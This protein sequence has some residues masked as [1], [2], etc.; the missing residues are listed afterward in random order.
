MQ[1]PQ[2]LQARLNE[3]LGAPGPDADPLELGLRSV[4]HMTAPTIDAVLAQYDDHGL[5]QALEHVAL[6]F[7]R[8]R[9]DG[10]AFSPEFL[11]ELG[12]IQAEAVT[13]PE[14]IDADSI[15]EPAAI[16]SPGL[17]AG[18][19]GPVVPPAPAPAS[20][21]TPASTPATSPSSAPAGSDSSSSSPSPAGSDAPGSGSSSGEEHPP[22]PPWG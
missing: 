1:S 11:D 4:V 8:M 15:E 17:P 18:A 3:L 21:P 16:A 7:V 12:K 9:S 2:K 19:P 20:D 5:D 13:H 10:S 14:A 22:A 6:F